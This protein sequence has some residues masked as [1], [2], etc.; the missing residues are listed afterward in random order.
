MMSLLSKAL[1]V[2]RA[3]NAMPSMSGATPMLSKRL[4]GIS[5]KHPG[6][7]DSG[8]LYKTMPKERGRQDDQANDR[9]KSYEAVRPA[10]VGR[11]GAHFPGVRGH[12][13]HRGGTRRRRRRL[14]ALKSPSRDGRLRA[15]ACAARDQVTNDGGRGRGH[16][17]PWSPLRTRALWRWFRR[18]LCC[19]WQPAPFWRSFQVKAE[20]VEGRPSISFRVV[21]VSTASG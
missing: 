9:R 4:P 21:P 18:F 2:I 6:P 3:P 11:Q 7:I 5:R 13:H 10:G 19:C 12:I 15:G 20:A 17:R 8:V 1:S 14:P 16:A